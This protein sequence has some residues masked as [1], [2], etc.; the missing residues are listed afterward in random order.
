M[1]KNNLNKDFL[2][3]KKFA[4]IVG[5]TASA[6]RH[7]DKKG[8]FHPAK[9]GVEFENKYRY[10]SPTQI[11]T[12]KMIRVLSE[13]GMP[14][15]EIKELTYNRTP[16]KLIK[17]LSKNKDKIANEICFYQE[18]FS[19][20]STFIDLLT[21]GMSVT[22]T[23]IS[24]SK[25]PEKRLIL[26]DENDFTGSSE[27]YGEFVRFCNA[28]HDPKLNLLTLKCVNPHNKFKECFSNRNNPANS[29]QWLFV[30]SFLFCFF[31]AWL[32]KR[33]GVTANELPDFF[34]NKKYFSKT[35]KKVW[36]FWQ[37]HRNSN[38]GRNITAFAEAKGGDI[39]E[40]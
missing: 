29:L 17:M 39:Y 25:M 5:M 13:I 28:P 2:S 31:P 24:V 33:K 14:L 8:I 7:Y 20:I 11:T 3:I 15:N 35:L 38:R 26:G 34:I 9:H 6:L 23:E 27:F 10:Y 21:E 4:E 19:V 12:V 40:P 32:C 36:Q 37:S 1:S 22:E 18:I 30:G 16:E